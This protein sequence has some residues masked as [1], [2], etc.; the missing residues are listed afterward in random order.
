M[1][2]WLLCLFAVSLGTLA[3]QPNPANL[4]P[5]Q[6]EVLVESAGLSRLE[7]PNEVLSRV[8]A[9][10]SDLRLFDAQGNEVPYSIESGQ[11]PADTQNEFSPTVSELDRS[12]VQ[13]ERGESAYR[14]IYRLE[15]PEY[16]S[17]AG[18]WSLAARTSS[19][20]F[21]R[22][23][24]IDAVSPEGT[25]TPLLQNASYFRVQQS[26]AEKY[27]FDFNTFPSRTIEVNIEGEGASFLAPDF[28]L[29]QGPARGPRDADE[30]PLTILQSTVDSSGSTLLE[31]ERPRAV[32]VTALRFATTTPTFVRRI[33]AFDRAAGR[34]DRDL[35]AS[36]RIFRIPAAVPIEQLEVTIQ[37]PFGDR[38]VVLVLNQDSP[39]LEGLTVTAVTARPALLFSMT[40]GAGDAPAG[41]LRFGGARAKRPQYD[42]ASLQ[43]VMQAQSAQGRALEPPG[44]ARLGALTANASY[45]PEPLLSFAS[46]AG[47]V[48]DARAYTH[49]RT[50]QLE[51][52]PEGL[53]RIE[54]SVQDAAVCRPDFADVR[55]TD[56]GSAQWAYLLD[57]D[58]RREW[59]PLDV[60]NSV[61]ENGA[62]NYRL[63]LPAD[64]AL[65]DGIRLDF[66]NAYFDR[67]Y[68]LTAK[69]DGQYQF[70]SSD[71]LTGSG[72]DEAPIEREF[73]AVRA[74]ELTLT[75]FDGN[76]Q[77][78]PAP[79]VEGR[80]PLPDLYT[81]APAGEY[82]LLL[83]FP[84]DRPPVY[85]LAQAADT[86]LAARA[87]TATAGE[88]IENP[89]FSAASR[90]RTG[91][92]SQ[93]ALFWIALLAAVG[94]LAVMTLKTV[95][96]ETGDAS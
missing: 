11:S 23:I 26:Q 42:L 22:R 18:H 36:G 51:P 68:E 29:Y 32:A 76:D 7:L 1:I 16:V 86:V 14:E 48:I 10:L 27:V 31:I 87:G 15:L 52:S 3:A 19:T 79:T 21:V 49:A 61:T 96:G 58:A 85:E 33:I 74:T 67:T 77:P 41:I 83:G 63:A 65:I 56:A 88:I 80:F 4:F 50:V 20:E 55:L 95:R 12:S 81:V 72:G 2:R 92:G 54:L 28:L 91:P 35:G 44:E 64:L 90:L 84:D 17:L 39:P 40:P 47:A 24:T 8:A 71:R 57:R 37:P 46:R 89:A 93:R 70:L 60:S 45:S 78:L 25:R 30:V 82:K 5:E 94:V 6:A 9:D 62:T 53:T 75:I 59:L 73:V 66:P 38:L 13:P 69:V 34:R 43:S